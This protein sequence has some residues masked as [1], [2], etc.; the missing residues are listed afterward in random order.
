MM[1][2]T[3]PRVQVPKGT[4]D[5]FGD[6]L[7]HSE[8][9]EV[10][11]SRIARGYGFSKVETPTYEHLQVFEQTG[12]VSPDKCFIFPDKSGR[13][14]ILRP[15]LNAPLCRVITSHFQCSPMPVKLFNSQQVYRYRHGAKRR[16]FK[17]FGLEVFGEKDVQADAEVVCVMLDICK[18]LG[19]TDLTV[20][21]SNV[22]I[23]SRLLEVAGLGMDQ[24]RD[25]LH[26][27]QLCDGVSKRIECVGLLDLPEIIKV[28]LK[29]II[30]CPLDSFHQR[31]AFERA[32]DVSD[33]LKAERV[34]TLSFMRYLAAQGVSDVSLRLDNIRGAGFYSDLVY[35]INTH[36]NKSEIAD[37]GRYDHFVERLGGVSLPAT[38]IGFGIGRL[39][40]ILKES[41]VAL[42]E[43]F[44]KKV[45]FHVNRP[46]II[47][48]VKPILSSSR[49]K[50][51]TV[52]AW[53]SSGGRGCAIKY[54]R[55]RGCGIM[56][57]VEE[58]GELNSTYTIQVSYFADSKKKND[59]IAKGAD[60]LCLLIESIFRGLE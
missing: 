23:F 50:E 52:E 14:L 42:P 58:G 13:Q 6:A 59:F 8:Y 45:L 34:K 30:S 37:G 27:L 41:G 25:V 44:N 35:R 56:V 60:Q 31:L 51:M 32:A 18:E 16:E 7:R 39:I 48:L 2:K 49:N 1:K 15:D 22:S 20:E 3:Y 57:S 12:I 55:K 4:H 9:V 47:G 43:S 17:M 36:Q 5:L 28:I 38:G 21:V 24:C 46:E 10:I 33:T 40:R 53:F 19:L 26:V 29:S 54:A 11:A